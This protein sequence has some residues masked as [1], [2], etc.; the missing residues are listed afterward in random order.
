MTSRERVRMALEHK[1]P[2]RVPIDFGCVGPSGIS[3]I[4][5]NRLCSYLGIKT[6]CRIFDLYQQIVIPDEEVLQRF[7]VDLKA[8]LPR[9]EKWRPDKLADGSLCQVPDGWRPVTLPDGSRIAYEGDNVVARMPFNGHYFDHVYWP[10]ANTTIDDLDDFV[11]PAPF[12]FYKLPD[13]NNLDIY[14]DDLRSEARYW[15]ENSEY[16]LVGSFGGSIFEAASGLMGY[17]RFFTDLILNR[18]FV[19]KL[20]D[21]LVRANIEYAKRYLDQ[22]GDYVDVIMVGGEDIGTQNGL[23]ISP[24]IYREV[25]KPRQRALWEFIKKNSKAFLLLHV[26]GSI[27]ELI[28][29]Y[30]ELGIDAINPVQVS[31]ANMDSR[32]L[33]EKYGDKITF[34]GGGCD[35]QSILPFGSPMDVEKEVKRR[36]TD[37]APGGGFIFNQV[38]IIQSNVPPKNIVTLYDVANDY[39]KY[40][41][42]SADQQRGQRT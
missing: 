1:E 30:I 16:A 35:T 27:E 11:W 25:V 29:D 13:V 37:F 33:K 21:K 14:L 40:P 20:M 28:S 31:A 10:L 34:W 6:E 38:H 39:G 22:V 26:C 8:V 12:S 17:E 3:A 15:Y 41:L 19:E 18:Q 5:Y 4:A 42:R 32:M 24:E 2:D 36:I 7:N 9:N 23:V